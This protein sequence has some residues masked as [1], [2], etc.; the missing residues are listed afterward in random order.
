M[1]LPK[2]RTY[3]AFRIVA[4]LFLLLHLGIRLIFP[5]PSIFADLVIYNAIAFLAAVGVITTPRFNDYWAKFAIFLALCLWGLASTIS[6]WNTFFNFN[7]PDFLSELSYGFF[8]PLICFGIFR[9]LT[10]NRKLISLELFDTSIIALGTTS[11]VASLLLK[12]AML[13]FQGSA[14][15]VFFAILYPVGDVVILG[16]T[17]ALALMQRFHARSVILLI[18]VIIFAASDLYFLW[19]S[20]NHTYQFGSLTDDGWLIALCLIAESLWHSGGEAE[21]SDRVNS[22]ATTISLILSAVILAIAALRPNYFPSF[23]LIPGF[24]TILLAFFRMAVAIRDTKQISEEREL[25]RTDELTGLP[26]RRRFLAELELLLR[27]EGTLLI[28]DLN[29][30]KKVNDQYG[31]DIGDQLLRQV[32]ARFSRAISVDSLIAR[33]GGDEFGVIVYGPASVGRE[34]ALALRSTLTYP[35]ALPPGEVSVG[36]SIG[37]CVNNKEIRSKEDLLRA[38]DSAMYEAKRGDLGLVE[39]EK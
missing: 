8:Y 28:L 35:F 25:A 31:H 10:F 23:V 36:V 13:H 29:G 16:V 9:A 14:Y 12:P 39:R 32:A 1:P 19:I 3:P 21:L 24:S 5:A 17:I 22:F 4:P 26:N 20:N 7:F 38:A 33:L 34:T 6:T 2:G 11:V 15:S 30:F 37:A 18:G 27:K